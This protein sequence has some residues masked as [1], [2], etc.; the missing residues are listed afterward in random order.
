MRKIVIAGCLFVGFS[1]LAFLYIHNPV[2]CRAAVIAIFCLSLWLT[3]LIPLYATTLLL[4]VAISFFLAPLDP[5]FS[6][7]QVL[8]WAAQPVLALFF[9]GFVM[10]VAMKRYALDNFIAHQILKRSHGKP[11]IVLLGVLIG[12]AFLS[13]WM[14]NIAAA[15]LMFAALRPLWKEANENHLLRTPLLLSVAY[16]ANFGGM[17]TPIGTG[18]NAIAIAEVQ[19]YQ[20][21]TFVQWM[22]LAFPLTVGMLLLTFFVLMFLHRIPKQKIKLETEIPAISFDAKIILLIFAVV[23]ILWLTES[24]HQIPSAVIALLLSAVLFGLRLLDYEDLKAVDWQTLILIAGGLILGELVDRSGLAN[25]FASIVAWHKVSKFSM[26]IGFVLATAVLSAIA[27][28][29]A[30]AALTIPIALSVNPSPALAII[31]A[32]GASMG[33]PFIISTP[34]NAMA[35]GEGGLKPIHFLIPGSILMLI[36]CLLI[37]ATGQRVLQVVGIP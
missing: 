29:T 20:S 36:G 14:S 17:A 18:P 28:N 34:P 7:A 1:A 13:M 2:I 24:I 10:G 26:I 27:S 9:G 35:F 11:I 16:G 5:K 37:S 4:V 31:L 21:V 32:M 8:S 6:F 15:A 25:N 30:A 33:A 23:I 12:T 22:L 3:E 19:P